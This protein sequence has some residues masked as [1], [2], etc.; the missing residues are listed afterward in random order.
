MLNGDDVYDRLV[1]V[2]ATN[3]AAREAGA[4]RVVAGSPDAS[5]PVRKLTGDLASDEGLPMPFGGATI[6]DAEIERIRSWIAGGAP[7]E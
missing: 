7:A 6:P 3:P 1:G 2:A 5:F 4:L